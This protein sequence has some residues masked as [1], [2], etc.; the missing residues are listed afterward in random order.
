MERESSSDNEPQVE[1]NLTTE[2]ASSSNFDQ[3]WDEYQ[4]WRRQDN[5]YLDHMAILLAAVEEEESTEQVVERMLQH[6]IGLRGREYIVAILNGHPK[7]CRNM[8][9][10]EVYGFQA[11][12][13][14]LRTDSILES[15]REVS[16]EKAVAMFAFTVGHGTVQRVTV[17]Q[18]LC[19]LA[20]QV[21]APTHV[22][23]VA[24]YIEGNPRHYPW[25]EKCYGAIDGTYIDAWAPAEATNAYISWHHR[26]SQ[27]VLAACDF[28][29]RFTYIY[30]GWEGTAHDARIF[31]DALTRPGINFP[32]PPEGYYYLVDSAYPC[33]QGFLPPYPRVRYHRSERHGNRS[34]HGYQ[35]YFNYWHSSLRNVIE[36]SFGVL[37]KRFRILRSMNPYKPTNQRYIVVACCVIHNIIRTITPDDHIFRQ[38]S[39]PNHYEGQTNVDNPNH[40]LH[41]PD[42]SSGAAQAMAATSESIAQPMWAHRSAN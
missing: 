40:I 24:P 25:F 4:E 2:G 20:P 30:A 11:L 16:V 35:D 17:M 28:D 34:F 12:C 19:R 5:T 29:M 1:A 15:T 32:W 39:N 13:N 7:N 9:R 21:I 10:M 27:N 36:R 14:T 41:T 3:T 8:F 42:M 38:F 26:V 33:T 18:A 22:D 23:G 37:K 31:M 6:N